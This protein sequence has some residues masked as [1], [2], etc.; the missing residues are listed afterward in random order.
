MMDVIG[1]LSRMVDLVVNGEPYVKLKD[2][3]FVL[4]QVYGKDNEPKDKEE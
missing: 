1:I 3:K 4:E 2:V